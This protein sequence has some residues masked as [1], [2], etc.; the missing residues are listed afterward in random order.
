M[1]P[2]WKIIGFLTVLAGF[3]VDAISSK[4]EEEKMKEE[5]RKTVDEV[6]AERDENTE[7]ESK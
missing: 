3:V 6:L 1:K 7:E 2:N 5:I 4:V